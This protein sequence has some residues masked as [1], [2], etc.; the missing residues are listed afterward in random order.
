MNSKRIDLNGSNRPVRTRMPG[1]VGGVE[2]NA[3]PY[4]DFC[5][6]KNHDDGDCEMNF[7][8]FQI[9]EMGEI[10]IVWTTRNVPERIRKSPKAMS[11]I[12]RER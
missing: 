4:P 8:V 10:I 7:E 2:L 5:K 11:R 12:V 9:R 3:P 6:E 1:G